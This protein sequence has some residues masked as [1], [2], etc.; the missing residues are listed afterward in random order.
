MLSPASGLLYVCQHHG[1][2]SYVEDD[3]V[4][5]A[6]KPYGEIKSEIF[7]LKYKRDHELAGI[8]NGNRL[9]KMILATRS[10][11]YSMK[12]GGQWCRIIHNYQQPVCSECPQEGRTRRRCPYIEGRR[13]K[14]KGHMSYDCD[15][16]YL[17]EPEENQ[18]AE[19]SVPNDMSYRGD[20]TKS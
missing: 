16:A 6:L 3:E 19:A 1:L 15:K 13:C 10:I 4:I 14:N 5:E 20:K 8:E 2:R 17:N 12:I 11:S 18:G 9:F 7:R